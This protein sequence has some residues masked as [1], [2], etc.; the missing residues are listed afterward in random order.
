M[1]QKDEFSHLSDEQLA[2]IAGVK[3]K[4]NKTSD[5]NEFSHLSDEELAEIAG[6][7]LK[8]PEKQKEFSFGEYVKSLPG[9]AANTALSI[10]PELVNIPHD[11]GSVAKTLGIPGVEKLANI[12]RL[13]PIKPF[14]DN[15]SESE[16]AQNT[17][18]LAS[19]VTGGLAGAKKGLKYLP[20]AT[21]KATDF[22]KGLLKESSLKDVGKKYDSLNEVIRNSGYSENVPRH[23]IDRYLGMKTDKPIEISEFDPQD[24]LKHV[25]N[26]VL[27]T[28][29]ERLGNTPSYKNAHDVQSYLGKLAEKSRFT[30]PSRFHDLSE[31]RSALKEDI[32]DTFMKNGDEHL[33]RKLK[34]I[35]DEYSQRSQRAALAKFLRQGGTVSRTGKSE[36]AISVDPRKLSRQFEKLS[37]QRFEKSVTPKD[38]DIIKTISGRQKNEKII[39]N[40]LGHLLKG[41]AIGTGF[42]EAGKHLGE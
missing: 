32:S 15:S 40:I 24:V 11:I 2:K 34:E 25:S 5:S 23:S 30:E 4:D 14:G 7:K 35:S 16:F 18:D 20:T 42:Y 37:D 10:G 33:V 38:W 6:V 28:K 1:N 3:L 31:A 13:E 12:P 36:S 8:E 41:T 9:A 17:T 39:K 26:K 21:K 29:L 22:Y 27:K 19:L